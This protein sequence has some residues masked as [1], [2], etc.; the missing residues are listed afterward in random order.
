VRALVAAFAHRSWRTFHAADGRNDAKAMPC[1][2]MSV[3][4]QKKLRLTRRRT[5]R[6]SIW[7]R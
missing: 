5:A 3:A 2:D 7:G 6:R 4:P 1:P